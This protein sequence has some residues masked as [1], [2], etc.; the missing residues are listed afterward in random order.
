MT[1]ALRAQNWAA[2][3]SARNLEQA[4]WEKSITVAILNWLAMLR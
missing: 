3:K 2:M 1:L 4:E